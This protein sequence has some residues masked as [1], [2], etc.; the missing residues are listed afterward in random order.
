MTAKEYFK[1]VCPYTD[2]PCE[3]WNCTECEVEKAER[4]YIES[5]VITKT[6]DETK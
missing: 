3:D 5:Y 2:K 1:G 6:K 4:E